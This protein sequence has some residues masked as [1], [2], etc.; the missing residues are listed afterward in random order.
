MPADAHQF[1]PTRIV[2]HGDAGGGLVLVTL[3]PSEDWRTSYTCAGQYISVRGEVGQG[4]YFALAGD[5]GAAHW[6]VIVRAGGDSAAAVLATADGGTVQ[7]T[8]ALGTGFPVQEARARPLLFA[9][10]GSGI[11]AARPVVLHRMRDGDAPR[12]SLLLG[13]RKREDVPLREEIAAWR[14]M[15]V[16]V[17]VCLSREDA[18]KDGADFASGYVQDVA[19]RTT[20]PAETSGGM[21]F[22]AGVAPMIEGM[23]ALASDLGVAEADVRMNY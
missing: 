4:G 9:T 15:G 16:R 6:E 3:A 20:T 1:S 8:R 10:T 17:T 5:V 13:V 12:T 21:I 7:T 18:P 2:A 11:A 22:A 14:T 23:R 19:R